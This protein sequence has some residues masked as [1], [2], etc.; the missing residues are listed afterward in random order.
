MTRPSK[1]MVTVVTLE[2]V[3][4]PAAWEFLVRFRKSSLAA[5]FYLAGGTGLA[6]QLRH[7]KSFD[8]DFFQGSLSERIPLQKIT[9]ELGQVFGERSL[10]QVSRQSDQVIWDVWGT[11]V[12]FIA[13]PFRLLEPLVD[14]GKFSRH[15]A[16]VRL[17]APKEIAMMKAYALG[18]RATFRDYVDLYFV[19]K[20]GYASLNDI[21]AGAEE[22]FVLDDE[23]LFST[24]LFLEQ[25]A[26]TKDLEDLDAALNLLFGRK[27]RAEEITALLKKEASRFIQET[28][29]DKRE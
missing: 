15:L 28:V 5:S 7:R 6:L 20:E 16:G 25:L 8:L 3:L 18:R 13:Y 24:R 1:R 12:S 4:G 10:K 19:I 2:E 21:I 14:A 27:V 23:K 17:A 26:Y 22:K 29:M 9:R 11:K